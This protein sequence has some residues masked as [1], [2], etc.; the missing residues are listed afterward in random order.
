LNFR[1]GSGLSCKRYENEKLKQGRNWDKEEKTSPLK[2]SEK[3]ANEYGVSD[4]TI[5]NDADFAKGVD[6]LPE[7]RRTDVSQKLEKVETHK[8]LAGGISCQ[9]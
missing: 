2:T 1:N 3:L 9:D 4:R 5:K 6:L 8:K 7:E